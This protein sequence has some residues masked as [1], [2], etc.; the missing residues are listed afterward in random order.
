MSVTALRLRLLELGYEP[1]ACAG[2]VP[3]LC[4]WQ[5]IE[6]TATEIER[7]AQDLSHA[8]NT[9]VRTKYTPAVDV[10]IRD[11][12]V[13][14]RVQ[15][16]I[17]NIGGGTFLQRVGQ[18]P[19]RLI[20]FRCETPFRKLFT[21]W[22]TISAVDPDK[23]R[24]RVE[25]LGDGQQF[26]GFGIHPD[27]HQPYRWANGT[28][29]TAL[30]RDQLPLLDEAIAR[31]LVAE[32][33]RIMAEAGWH[34]PKVE[35]PTPRATLAWQPR[36]ND[37][38]RVASALAAIPADDRDV[39]F[40]V[41]AI[42]KDQPGGRDLWD[43]WSQ[44]ASKYDANDQERVWASIGTSDRRA[45][46]ASVFQLALQHGWRPPPLTE[47]EKKPWRAAGYF[48]WRLAP[49]AARRTFLHWCEH[50]SRPPVGRVEA[51]RIFQTLLNKDS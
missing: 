43:R 10:D 42:L 46:V 13:A 33:T 11:E 49:P 30:P 14:D 21:P 50:Y 22:F 34:T 39:W 51:E 19:K 44:S 27:T 18:P 38:Q 45:T 40:K 35:A 25:V 1:V 7:W 9:G 6:T 26:V 47:A 28:D 24:N 29:L 20:P 8:T 31:E 32:T 15:Q 5:T 4:G 16:A 36:D 17:V 12:A 37:D 48:L 2:K 41:G 3:V 23:L